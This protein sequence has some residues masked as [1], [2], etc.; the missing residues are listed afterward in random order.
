MVKN[1]P[2]NTGDVRDA[3]ST[4]E[5]GSS[6]GV[7]KGNP[8]QYSCLENSTGR[9]ATGFSPWGHKQADMTDCAHTQTGRRWR[10]RWLPLENFCLGLG[11]DLLTPEHV[12]GRAR[13][14][15]E[16]PLP[17]LQTFPW[18][19]G[20]RIWHPDCTGGHKH[21]SLPGCCFPPQDKVIVLW[22]D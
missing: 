6:P 16:G 19:S 18:V 5:S 1:P 11:K 9:G 8:L 4:P 3:G 22:K 21:K 14:R 17:S 13:C 2:A 15:Q 7:G 12:L 20:G 10:L